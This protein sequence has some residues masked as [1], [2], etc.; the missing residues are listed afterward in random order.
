MNPSRIWR[1]LARTH[2]SPIRMPHLVAESRFIEQCSRCDACLKA[3][4][5]G[6]ITKG[7]GGFP[8]LNFERAE[9]TFC[10]DCARACPE[11]L[12]LNPADAPWPYRAAFGSTCLPLSGV[13]C[14][15]CADA[16]DEMA[17]RFRPTTGAAIP[18]LTEECTGC[19]ACLP[20]CPNQA[21]SLTPTR[22]G[23]IA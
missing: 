5:T 11:P 23:E 12:F 10:G 18:T 14:R 22:Q 7:D 9:C 6:V 13:E 20:R 16:C 4:E 19:G 3:C 15:S 1:R 21:L 2:S 8:E 17:I